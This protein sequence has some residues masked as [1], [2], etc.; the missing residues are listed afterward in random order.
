MG[1]AMFGLVFLALIVVGRI[2]I[3]FIDYKQIKKQQVR[4]HSLQ[5]TINSIPKFY[6]RETL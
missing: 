3:E 1:A 4:E 2:I 6:H 5:T